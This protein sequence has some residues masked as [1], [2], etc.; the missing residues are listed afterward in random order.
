[1]IDRAPICHRPSRL[2]VTSPSAVFGWQ[3]QLALALLL[4]LTSTIQ[5]SA[6]QP[7]AA[8]TADGFVSVL[9]SH[10]RETFSKI[11]QD[12]KNRPNSGDALP[13]ADWLLQTAREFGWEPDAAWAV[14]T[15]LANPAADTELRRKA[16]LVKAIGAARMRDEA[17]ATAAFN[18]F[19][20]GLRL[21]Q[22]NEAAQAA[23]SLALAWQ[24]EGKP[25][26]ATL[27]YQQLRESFFLNEELRQ[28]SD[29][30]LQRL[31]L[32]GQPMPAI[33]LADLNGQP[34]QSEELT[35]QVTLLDFWATN[36]RPC[37]EELPR[38][39][40]LKS[41]WG[42]RVTFIGIS[43][44][45]D[46][47]HL[48]EFLQA[49]QIGWRQVLGQKVAEQDFHVRLIP[50]LMLVDAEGKLAAVDVRPEDLPAAIDRLVR[51]SP[52]AP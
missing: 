46:A 48:R 30:R 14:E 50:C 23:Q 11:L 49:N 1:M 8:E 28:F 7:T 43:F 21:R 20:Q 34:V 15:V 37:L 33:S 27:T 40:R 3:R 29:D 18:Q 16:L 19:L 32:V 35:G 31:A 45:E 5:L 2:R 47:G 52:T 12:Q 22:P 24:L 38:L 13:A 9:T 6:D 42:S 17:T 44:D 4:Q 39:R 25:E 36:C 41:A 10:T 26:L 51:R